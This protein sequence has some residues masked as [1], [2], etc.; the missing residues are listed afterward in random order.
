METDNRNFFID[1]LEGRYGPYF[2]Q[3]EVWP[4]ITALGIKPFKDG[5]QWCFLYGDNI[6]EG[7]AGFGDTVRNAAL[8]FYNNIYYEK[9]DGSRVH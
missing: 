6:Q 2:D 5:D 1:L 3:F 4:C 8:D 9:T 7:I